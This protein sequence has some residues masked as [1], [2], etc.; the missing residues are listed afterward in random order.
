MRAIK[1]VL[2]HLLMTFRGLFL[3]ACQLL[4]GLFLLFFI[5]TLFLG[6]SFDVW[7]Q[8]SVLA[9]AVGF[10][11]LGW[12]YDVLLLKLKPDNVDLTLFQ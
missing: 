3:T 2:F 4:S 6:S 1:A 11:A 10:G 5:V 8:M 12:Y 7:T 9:V